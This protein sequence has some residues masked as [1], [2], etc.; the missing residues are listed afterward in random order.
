MHPL[1]PF[2]SALCVA[3]LGACDAGASDADYRVDTTVSPASHAR[4]SEPIGEETAEVPAPGANTDEC[5]AVKLDPW[6]NVLP[7]ETI[8]AE[9][10]DTVGHGHIRYIAPGDE[11]TLDFSLSRLNVETGEDGRIKLFRCG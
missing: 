2:V 9:I 7:T 10:A 3:L 8:K 5:G 4:S 6:L 11:V 1:R